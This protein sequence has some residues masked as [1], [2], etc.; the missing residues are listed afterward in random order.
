[1]QFDKLPEKWKRKV[2]QASGI[3]KPANAPM[4]E[5]PKADFMY[6]VNQQRNSLTPLEAEQLMFGANSGVFGVTGY[7]GVIGERSPV[8]L[9]VGS[10]WNFVIR[11]AT[12]AQKLTFLLERFQS[13]GGRRTVSS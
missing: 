1:M 7:S 11:R 4:G 10:K 13:N 2:T 12:P 5:P 6:Y 9:K 8:R 3:L